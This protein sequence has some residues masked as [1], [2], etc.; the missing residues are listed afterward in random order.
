[1]VVGRNPYGKYRLIAA[2]E[3]AM[4]LWKL[5]LILVRNLFEI[6]DAVIRNWPGQVGKVLRRCYY[7]RRFKHL[8]RN[9][10]IE[11]GV[12]F[13][14]RPYISIDD[15]TH[16]DYDCF[17]VAGPIGDI[18]AEM[19]RLPNRR[20]CLSEGEVSIGKGV[21]IASG[22]QI[23]GHG[24]VQIGDTSACAAG[25]RILSITNHYA[26]FTDR[27]RRDVYFSSRA[28][29]EHASYLIGPIVLGKNVGVA[30]NCLLLPGVTLSDESFLHIG[31]VAHYGVIPANTVASG[32]PAV[33]RG[34][35][36]PVRGA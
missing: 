7:R 6:I 27:F 32:N 34:N 9:V 33:R 26:S 18:P 10:T 19:R 12:R 35:R 28:G 14:G 16:I 30:S 15:D 20:F 1:M 31:S 36:F 4:R 11:P 13:F 3:T 8:G 17:I 25:T 24:G 22:C 21:H 23:L 2:V 5:P 29:S